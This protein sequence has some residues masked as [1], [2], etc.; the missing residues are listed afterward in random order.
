MG[1]RLL[2]P[3]VTIGVDQATTSGWSIH[4][5]PRPIASG[6]VNIW[7]HARR[8]DVLREAM[9]LSAA[10]FLFAY[11]DHSKCPLSSYKSTGQVLSLGGALWLWF[12]SLCRIGHP[13]TMRMGISSRDWR[14]RVLGLSE[15]AGRK[16][17]KAEAIRW[18]EAHTRKVGIT[19]DEAD[20]ISV[21][22][23]G[24]IDGMRWCQ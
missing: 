10:P 20:A 23:Y 14:W 19:H 21:S 4:L 17:L 12:D 1:P 18:A 13:E 15:R 11:E 7:D 22:A 16:V 24:A 9:A 3:R 2:A 5:G 6:V 8:R